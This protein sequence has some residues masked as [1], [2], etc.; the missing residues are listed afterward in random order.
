[1]AVTDGSMDR[2]TAHAFARERCLKE[3]TDRYLVVEV[4]AT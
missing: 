3:T 2:E 1:V 4:L